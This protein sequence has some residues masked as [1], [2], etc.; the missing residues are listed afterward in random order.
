MILDGSVVVSGCEV[1]G[2]DDEYS[3]MF[4]DDGMIWLLHFV[5]LPPVGGLS[6]FRLVLSVVWMEVVT[7]RNDNV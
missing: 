2:Y 3:S 5:G 4:P 1:R 7:R 6:W